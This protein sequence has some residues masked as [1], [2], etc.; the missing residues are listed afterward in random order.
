MQ[1]I[2][3]QQ[4]AALITA[5]ICLMLVSM[6]GVISMR[7]SGTN[8]KVSANA[9]QAAQTMH[10]ATSAINQFFINPAAI[11]N[12]RTVQNVTTT[13]PPSTIGNAQVNIQA[14]YTGDFPCAITVGVSIAPGSDGAVANCIYFR[15]ASNYQNNS[16]GESTSSAGFWSKK[17]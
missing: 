6:M 3:K 13:F 12:L 1:N 5:L 17:D 10:L 15:V 9:K 7:T 11:W 8:A 14:E 4:G 16:G 2:K